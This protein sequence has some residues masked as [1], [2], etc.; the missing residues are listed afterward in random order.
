MLTFLKVKDFAIIDEVRIEFDE[1][2]S[3]ITGETGAGKS[4]IINA[5]S[6]LMNAKAPSAIVRNNT[7][8]AEVSG[9][10][11]LGNKE[12]I[13]KRVIGISGR[14]KAFINEDPVTLGRLEEMGR[15][16]INIYGQNEFQHLLNKDNYVRIID[17]LLSL[18]EERK[19]FSEKVVALKLVRMECDTRKK[20][21][22]GKE[23]EICLLEF[24]IN[25]IEKSTLSEE[26][27][28]KIR[29]KLKLLKDAEK[30]RNGLD[31]ITESLYGSDQSMHSVC[32]TLT[33]RLKPFSAIEMIDALR[34]RM[35][36]LSLEMEDIMSDVRAVEKV[37]F[38]DPAELEILESRLSLIFQLK[39]KYGKTYHEIKAFERSARER[40]VYLSAL[41]DNIERLEKERGLLEKEVED[42]AQALSDKRKEG[43]QAVEKSIVSELELLSIKGALFR[44]AM[45][46]KGDI[47]EEGMDEIE[48]LISTNYGEPLKPL[49]KIA[50]GG[51][52]SRIMLAMKRVVGGEEE[53]VLI[54]DEVDAGIGGMVADMVGKRL[55]ALARKHQVICITHLPQIAV[56]GDHHYLV[57]K[58][59]EGSGTKT[60]IRRLSGHERIGEVARMMGSANLTEKTLQR[61]EE[62][63]RN[64]KK[65]LN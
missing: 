19:T 30:I 15:K 62:M 53:K 11:F 36:A 44:I 17:N 29:E 38:F 45:E 56:Y 55:K 34:N 39:N 32:K 8:Q 61:A 25:E 7:A 59:Q 24:Q 1:G 20:E 13:V 43:I 3:I 63:L 33:S 47:D 50:S 2:L 49:R 4:I 18:T 16:L 5:L 41:T 21:A 35:E 22:E 6:T 26:E 14:S 58:K 42:L 31:A 54:F 9:H 28:D 10:F 52:L 64:V 57:E 27:E 48:L 12:F 65:G 51:E 60:G 23:K 46:N 40:L 37:A